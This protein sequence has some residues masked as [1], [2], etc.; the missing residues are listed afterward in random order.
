MTK[1]EM[2]NKAF[3]LMDE[4]KIIRERLENDNF[5]NPTTRVLMVKEK[6]RKMWQAKELLSKVIN[7]DR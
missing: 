7:Y 5:I 6:N 1:E 4:Q 3:K 2:R